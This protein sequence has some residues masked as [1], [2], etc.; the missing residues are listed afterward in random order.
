[1]GLDDI[2]KNEP[3]VIDNH[4]LIK[5]LGEIRASGSDFEGVSETQLKEFIK[6]T[7][8]MLFAPIDPAGMS[9]SIEEMERSKETIALA[10]FED[11]GVSRDT[12]QEI[13]DDLKRR[14][15]LSSSVVQ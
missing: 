5:A 14:R 6:S 1:M 8:D 11:M 9:A 2:P 3:E 10:A 7:R 12:G 4:L 15:G 13:I